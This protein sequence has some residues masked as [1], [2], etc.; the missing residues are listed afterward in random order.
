MPTFADKA[1][2]YFS[3]LKTPRN[4]PSEFQIVNPYDNAEVKRIVPLFFNKFYDDSNERLFVLGINHG[5]FGGGTTGLSFTDPVALREFCGIEN[6][7]GTRRELSSR[8]IYMVVQRFGAIHG[9]ATPQHGVPGLAAPPKAAEFFSKIFLSALYPLTILTGGR[10]RNPKGQTHRSV[11]T[12]VN[13]NYYDDKELYKFLRNDIVS[14]VEQQIKIGARRDL[15]VC[16]GRRNSKFLEEINKEF[17]LFE[18]I[19]VLD[20]PRWIMQYRLKSVEKYVE[21]YLKVLKM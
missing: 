12:S 8:F 14:S 1:I 19:L 18:E 6:S 5:R 2:R 7:L 10:T 17:K 4:I 11:P 15:I 3:H 9:T 20:H 13:C 21:E 16:L